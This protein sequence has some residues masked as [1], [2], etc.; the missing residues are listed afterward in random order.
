MPETSLRLAGYPL[1]R[2]AAQA[3]LAALRLGHEDGERAAD[4]R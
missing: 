4:L 3:G 1:L 2:C